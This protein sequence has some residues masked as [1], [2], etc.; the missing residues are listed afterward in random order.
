MLVGTFFTWFLMPS[1]LRLGESQ[2]VVGREGA[3]VQ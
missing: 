2:V 1:L 3:L